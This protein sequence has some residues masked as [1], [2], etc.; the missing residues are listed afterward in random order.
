MKILKMTLENI[1]RVE[2]GEI[3]ADGANVLITGPNGSGKSTYKNAY[4]LCL[5]GKYF[6]WTTGEVNFQDAS[7]N[8]IRDGK[9]HAVE[10]EFESG[11]TLRR[12]FLNKFD[13][14]KNFTGLTQKFFVDGV[15][16]KQKEFDAKV[17]RLTQG[18][19]LNPFGFCK[20]N[21]KERRQILMSMIE[22]DDAEILKNFPE[23]QLGKLDAQSFIDAK[24][25]V[26]RHIE[27]E[28]ANIPARIDELKQ[29]V[30][31]GDISD[32]QQKKTPKFCTKNLLQYFSQEI[33]N[34]LVKLPEFTL[35]SKT[36]FFFSNKSKFFTV[37]FISKN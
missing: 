25:N 26:I 2:R 14:Q 6:D 5:T 20:M 8:Y 3:F 16:M 15:P 29:Q 22:V 27:I 31:D 9:V 32:L 11:L 19:P 33:K 18:A 1:C 36:S 23:L 35:Y 21:W 12:E 30:L 24:K 17:Y 10:V 7:G 4:S 13:K 28:L 37:F 34:F